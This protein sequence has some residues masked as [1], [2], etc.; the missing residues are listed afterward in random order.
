MKKLS[1]CPKV[2]S[3]ARF[4]TT[5][6][7]FTIELSQ[8]GYANFHFQLIKKGNIFQRIKIIESCCFFGW[9]FLEA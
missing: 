3:L 9:C 1:S 7:K 8:A 6:E 5:F 4:K 2:D